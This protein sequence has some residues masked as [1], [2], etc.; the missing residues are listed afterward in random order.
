LA[1]RILRR[2]SFTL[3]YGFEILSVGRGG[4]DTKALLKPRYLAGF[5]RALFPE[6]YIVFAKLSCGLPNI[7][8]CPY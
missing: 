3:S 2:N 6:R 8:A 5:S 7:I 4:D 1:I